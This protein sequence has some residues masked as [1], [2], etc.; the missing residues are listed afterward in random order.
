L[1]K[2][3]AIAL[4]AA[5]A[6]MCA[7]VADDAKPVRLRVVPGGAREAPPEA[8]DILFMAAR[9]AKAEWTFDLPSVCIVTN[10]TDGKRWP[11]GGWQRPI[12]T[13]EYSGLLHI[14]E[15]GEYTFY[16]RR[17]LMG[18]AYL[19]INGD[20]VIEIPNR[21]RRRNPADYSKEWVAGKSVS[22]EKGT[23]EFR[24]LGYCE[25]AAV[26]P[27]AWMRGGDTNITVIGADNFRRAERLHHSGLTRP[28]TSVAVDASIAG[29][30][31]FLIPEDAVRPELHVRS[32]AGEVEVQVSVTSPDEASTIFAATSRVVM[33]KQW[34]RFPLPSWKA[35]EVGRISWSA[36]VGGEM[37]ARGATRF[38]HAPFD[39][40][41]SRAFGGSLFAD[42]GTS[43][44]FVS[45]STGKGTNPPETLSGAAP[46]VLVDCCGLIPQPV[47]DAALRRVF[48]GSVPAIAKRLTLK[49][50][51]TDSAG[52]SS[53]PWLS[54]LPGL[55]DA[56]GDG[57]IVLIPDICVRD[58][59]SGAFGR[60]LAAVAGILSEA[61]K[62]NVVLVTPPRSAPVFGVAR[63]MRPYAETIHRVADL[64]GL[65]V[66]DAYTLDAP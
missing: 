38:V 11:M 23:V 52:T 61:K 7:S 63:D 4:A 35:G 64:Y 33:V 30:G 21:R 65:V 54:Y 10:G 5:M 25:R 59:G 3:A 24:A 56:A 26:F 32:D 14:P 17:P 57:T 37:V 47:L 58:E 43:C 22:F 53:Y 2:R 1:L 15:N 60:R 16:T 45:R 44:V 27:L 50:L 18:P 46:I 8:R 29:V 51:V 62:R 31:S 66:A 49:D 40:V 55:C 12:Q 13:F 42:D 9:P 48:G 41:P 20:P 19:F 39:M 36:S 34:G 28:V 6:A